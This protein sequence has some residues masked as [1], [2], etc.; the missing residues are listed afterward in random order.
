MSESEFKKRSRNF[1]DIIDEECNY[2]CYIGADHATRVKP[3]KPDRTRNFVPIEVVDEAA[4]DISDSIEAHIKK[5]VAFWKSSPEPY[6]QYY[7]D[8][9]C[10]IRHNILED[11]AFKLKKW[12]G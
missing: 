8:A 2:S 3:S 4:K 10:C 1:K 6:A 5:L 12:F 7:I 11:D 9:Y